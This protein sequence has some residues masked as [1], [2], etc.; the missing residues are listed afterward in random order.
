MRK[1]NQQLHEYQNATSCTDSHAHCRAVLV[2]LLAFYWS[3]SGTFR[4]LLGNHL[5]TVQASRHPHNSNT[6]GAL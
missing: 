6:D 1:K 2:Y 3:L 5:A 4:E